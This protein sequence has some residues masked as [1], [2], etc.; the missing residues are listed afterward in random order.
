MAT[1]KTNLKQVGRLKSSSFLHLDQEFEN[2]K[3]RFDQE[4]KINHIE[5]D[6]GSFFGLNKPL[7]LNTKHGYGK[8]GFDTEIKAKEH[9]VKIR[10]IYLECI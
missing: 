6:F 1:Q 5:S 9:I 2:M 4:M 10:Y 3:A 7:H 8:N